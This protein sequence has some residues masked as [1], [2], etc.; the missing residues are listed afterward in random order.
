[1]SKY[2][3]GIDFGTLSGRAVLADVTNGKELAVSTMDY[4]HGVISEILPTTGRRLPADW[5]LQDPRDY[6]DVLGHVIPEVISKSGVNPSDIIGVGI[7]FTAC[8]VIPTVRLEEKYKSNPHAYVKLWK[9]H[10]AEICRQADDRPEASRG[11]KQIG[12]EPK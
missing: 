7:D 9:H 2:A 5:A 8:T 6:L 12:G 3:I 10:A 4:P 1:M 11:D